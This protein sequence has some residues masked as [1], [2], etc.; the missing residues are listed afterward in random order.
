MGFVFHVI[1][2]GLES[3]LL[4][5]Y[6]DLGMAKLHAG[7]VAGNHATIHLPEPSGLSYLYG[8]GDGT[9][10]VVVRKLPR[11]W[12]GE[13]GVAVIERG[14]ATAE[15]NVTAGREARPS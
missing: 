12:A 2:L 9:F 11:Q 7:H 13:A 6:E 8:P 1:S 3:K 5:A 10:T 4:A 15:V 14:E